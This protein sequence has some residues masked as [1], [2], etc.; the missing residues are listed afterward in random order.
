MVVVV[1]VVVVSSL[2]FS[3]VVV[4][5]VVA[6]VVVVVVGGGVVVVVVSSSPLPE[7]SSIE[8]HTSLNFVFAKEFS[9]KN[10]SSLVSFV[11]ISTRRHSKP[12]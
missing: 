4:V 11:F 2:P 9:L 7:V 8:E 6:G 5:V 1:V 3:E 12:V 10:A